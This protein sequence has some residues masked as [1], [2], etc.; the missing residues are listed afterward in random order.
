MPPVIGLTSRTMPLP[1]N[2]RH[3]PTETVTRTY[4][5]ALERA[6]ALCMLIP[7]VDPARAE[8]YLARID[9]VLLTGGDD[10]DPIHFGE[11][12]HPQID[13]VDARRDRF[14]IELAR[15]AH[16]RGLPLFGICGGV[17]LFNIAL[18]GDIYQDIG[19][20]TES[21]IQHTQRRLD[22]GPWHDVRI[23][24]GS[25]LHAVV[26]ASS[27][28]V[29]SFHHQACRRPGSGLSVSAISKDGLPEAVEDSSRD[30]YLG[31]QWHPELGGAGSEALFAAFVDSARK[32]S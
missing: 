20:Q 5:E 27:L 14:E 15:G 30:F 7:N 31:V 26:Q 11:E 29:N 19:S 8:E 1:A 28:R 13:V 6:G 10:P 24:E 2:K 25:R 9:G 3:R 16:A 12:P 22:D 23:E 17:Q 4:V 21:A 32:S 18:G